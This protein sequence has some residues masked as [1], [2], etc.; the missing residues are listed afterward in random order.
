MQKWLGIAL[1]LAGGC[2]R[3]SRQMSKPGPADAATQAD[4]VIDTVAPAVDAVDAVAVQ[5]LD[6]APRQPRIVLA[7][8]GAGGF[9]SSEQFMVDATGAATHEAVSTRGVAT[10]KTGRVAKSTLAAV[11]ATL[12]AHA[13]CSLRADPHYVPV[14]EEQH[15]TLAVDLSADLVC[16]VTLHTN[17][18]QRTPDAKAIDEAIGTLMSR[19]ALH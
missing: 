6:A 11:T 5:P 8:G 4:A 10:R 2:G 15:T 16:S 13:V 14:P 7:W 3:S 9:G 1:V 19:A 12:Q 17:E 18:W